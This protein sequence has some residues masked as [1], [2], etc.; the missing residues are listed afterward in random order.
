MMRKFAT[1]L[2]I[3]IVLCVTCVTVWRLNTGWSFFLAAPAHGEILG[4]E[5]GVEVRAY[6]VGGSVRG[7]FGLEYECVELVNRYYVQVLGYRNMTRTGHAESYFWD[8]RAKGLI[9]FQNGSSTPPAIHDIL[10]FDG[11]ESDG[12]VGHVAVV[13]G[14]DVDAGSVTFI[15]Q[16]IR[17]RADA[18]FV[19]DVWKDT[20]ALRSLEGEWFINQGHYTF[21]VAGWSRVA[22]PAER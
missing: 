19:R 18:V 13:V 5:N 11:G 8:A 10:V 12:S 9:A 6:G 21:P 22:P 1:I 14:V 17:A 20:L 16:N 15:Q 2:F 3:G 4:V 7:E